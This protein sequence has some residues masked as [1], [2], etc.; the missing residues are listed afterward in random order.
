MEKRKYSWCIRWSFFL[1]TTLIL[2]WGCVPAHFRLY[3]DSS[4][5]EAEIATLSIDNASSFRFSIVQFDKRKISGCGAGGLTGPCILHFLPGEHD[6]RV[7]F[8]GL[9]GDFASLQFTAEAGKAY[10]LRCEQ[11]YAGETYEIGVGKSQ[12]YGLDLF[13]VELSSGRRLSTAMWK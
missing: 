1:L 6:M 10:S 5:T 11:E 9:F 13:I 3:T 7:R 8:G 12:K 4:L 2:L